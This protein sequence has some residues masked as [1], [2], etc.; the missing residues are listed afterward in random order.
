MI[1]IDLTIGALEQALELAS[2]MTFTAWVHYAYNVLKIPTVHA[3]RI[4]QI[5]HR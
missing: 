2:L 3:A 4:H 1:K 5:A